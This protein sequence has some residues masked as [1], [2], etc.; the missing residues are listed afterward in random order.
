MRVWE[1]KDLHIKLSKEFWMGMQFFLDDLLTDRHP[2]KA[3]GKQKRT[4]RPIVARYHVWP[5]SVTWWAVRIHQFMGLDANEEESEHQ[6]SKTLPSQVDRAATASDLPEECQPVQ[7]L[8]LHKLQ[9][10]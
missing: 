6:V 3:R 10:A 7:R 4:T 2:N 1:T 5:S 9:E 8:S